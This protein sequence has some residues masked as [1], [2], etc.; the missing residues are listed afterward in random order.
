MTYLP[1]TCEQPLLSERGLAKFTR[2]SIERLLNEYRRR[3]IQRQR[4]A[5]FRD[6]AYLDD[7]ILDDIG[8]SHA[9]I[10]WGLE[11]P[12]SENVARVVRRRVYAKTGKPNR[13][14]RAFAAKC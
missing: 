10:A 14:A 9:D 4:R 6:L 7:R 2:S 11:Q 8:L 1:T 13:A 3:Q 5:I 12:E